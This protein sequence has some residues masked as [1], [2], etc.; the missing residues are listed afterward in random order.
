MT[1]LQKCARSGELSTGPG[2]TYENMPLERLQLEQREDLP[3]YG[4]GVSGG[5]GV[6]FGT[7]GALGA[8]VSRGD[9]GM[10]TS[11]SAPP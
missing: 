7:L 5:A 10:S 8:F 1:F 2:A 11:I 9:G 6:T 4:C 3:R